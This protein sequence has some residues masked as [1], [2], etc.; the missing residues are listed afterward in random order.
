MSGTKGTIPTSN[1]LKPQYWP[2]PD[3]QNVTDDDQLQGPWK[4]LE[5]RTIHR[6]KPQ[7][8]RTKPGRVGVKATDED[9]WL[10]AGMYDAHKESAAKAESESAK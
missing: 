8:N 7:L 2:E 6:R 4:S 3:M 1:G 10:D 9:H 5:A